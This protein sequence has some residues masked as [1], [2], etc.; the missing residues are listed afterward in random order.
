MGSTVKGEQSVIV[1]PTELL[2]QGESSLVPK[3]KTKA[4]RVELEVELLSYTQVSNVPH[5]CVQWQAS[6]LVPSRPAAAASEAGC[7]AVR[8]EQAQRQCCSGNVKQALHV[9]SCLLT[10]AL[11]LT[12]SKLS[13]RLPRLHLQIR[14]LT[15]TGEVTKKRLR[16]GEGQFPVDCP[17]EDCPV[18]VHIRCGTRRGLGFRV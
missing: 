16:E 1:C 9:N 17:V 6:D 4:D 8:H 5:R 14:D 11:S 3:V 13:C 2:Q 18:Q 7:G 15:G 12:S 10:C